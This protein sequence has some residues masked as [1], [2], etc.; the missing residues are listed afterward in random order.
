MSFDSGL[1]LLSPQLNSTDAEHWRPPQG[2]GRLKPTCL[3]PGVQDCD[4]Y[5]ISQKMGSSGFCGAP[6]SLRESPDGPA[7]C[8]LDKAQSVTCIKLIWGPTRHSLGPAQS[9]RTQIQFSLDTLYPGWIY[10]G[11]RLDLSLG[12]DP[13]HFANEL[14]DPNWGFFPSHPGRENVA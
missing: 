12:P 11:P 4:L 14:S 10:P 6:I 5:Q 8:T 3:P 13:F 9:Y 7:I 1:V 2:R